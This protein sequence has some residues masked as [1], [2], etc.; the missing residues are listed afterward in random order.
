MFQVAFGGCGKKGKVSSEGFVELSWCGC[1]AVGSACGQRRLVLVVVV[2][3][4]VILGVKGRGRGSAGV[5]VT[6][7]RMI[8]HIHWA[9]C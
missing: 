5:I 1:R 2:G 4:A 9:Q 7:V 6:R 3:I 8:V